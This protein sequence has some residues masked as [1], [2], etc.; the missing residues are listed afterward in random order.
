MTSISPRQDIFCEVCARVANDPHHVIHRSQGGTDHEHNILYVC[1][2]CHNALHGHWTIAERSEDVLRIKDQAGEIIVEHWFPPVEFD[3][4]TFLATFGEALRTLRVASYNYF[5]YLD[6]DGMVAAAELLNQ[7]D[8]ENW[9]AMANLLRA[10][11]YK[12]PRGDRSEKFAALV[13]AFGIRKS[14]G[15][16]LI[17]ALEYTEDNPSIF[18]PMES[19]PPPDVVLMIKESN[20]PEQTALHYTER[21]VTNPR[22]SPAQLRKELAGELDSGKPEPQYCVCPTCRNIHLKKEE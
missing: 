2:E 4:A 17:M 11:K 14:K 21:V 7:L 15:Y 16:K 20:R 6:H 13:Q 1:R 5:R 9:M 22:Y 3:Q 8:A 19:L 10:A 18:P 12:M